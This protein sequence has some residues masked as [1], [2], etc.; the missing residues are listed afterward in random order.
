VKGRRSTYGFSVYIPSGCTLCFDD[1]S[2]HQVQ[3]MH[4][5][6]QKQKKSA[7]R[8]PCRFFCL[9]A[10]PGILCATS[11]FAQIKSDSAKTL[12]EVNVTG[13]KKQNPYSAIVP[14]QR[15]NHEALQQI[16]AESIA[17]AAR[18]FS[19]VLI[20]DYGGIG[21]LKTVSVRS[22]GGLNTGL[23]Y[24]G[25][26]IADAQ[27]GQADLGKYSATFVQSLEL[28][29]ANPQQIPLPA[30]IYS[31]ASVL[32]FTSNTY[33]ATN[34]SKNKWLAGVNAGSFGLWQPY[35][36]LYLPVGKNTILSANGEALWAKG[37]YPYRVE[38]GMFSQN[39]TRSNSDIRSFQG[40]VNMVNR[41]KDSS[42][43]QTK[44]WGYSSERGLPGS[45]IFFNDIAAQRLQDKNFFVQSQYLKKFGAATSLLVSAKYSSLF[46]K[47][48]DPNFLNN[49]G[50][51]D[52]HYTQNEIYGSLAVSHR[53]G[54]YFSISLA[55][56]LASTNLSANINEFPNPI[57]ISWWNSFTIQ[58]NKSHWQVN[59]SLLN[60]N[61]SDK[62]ETGV[63]ASNKNKFTPAFAIGYKP[64]PES[65]LLF[66]FFYKD[67]FRM[68]TF[69][70]LYYTYI[71]NTNRKLLPEYSNQY[72]A[73]FTFLKNFSPATQFSIS[74]DGYYN[75]IKDKIIAV[76]SQNLFI[77]TMQNIGKVQIKGI[78]LN[79]QVN[80]KFSQS[81]RWS[82]RLAYTWQQAIDV[83][84]P[85]SAEY[86]N[87][88][89]YTPN[90]S[91][92]ALA[93]LYYDKWSAGYSF[94]FSGV[95]YT[96]GENDPSNQ[97][98]GWNTQDVFIACQLNFR[99]FQT[100][101]RGDVN[102]IFD[103]QYDVVH[104]YPMPG[105]S[106]KLSIIIN[107]L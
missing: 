68:P 26:T 70:D 17:G 13:E 91:G 90:N 10:L 58:F 32:S 36:G 86:K 23:V 49:A 6:P 27:T 93:V 1:F 11:L 73:G 21:G 78:D 54:K 55:S 47:Y 9:L 8:T 104:Y 94:L 106:Y 64:S 25:I 4:T 56:D 20:K 35:A 38:N 2:I 62:T 45:I 5:K 81:L 3:R 76:P 37:N 102:N 79:G 100:T 80:G 33:S 69:N 99:E 22:L 61:L 107:N 15:L 52:D 85:A 77:W 31:S 66:R 12:Q 30:R 29:L 14:V 43:I 60:T 89:P 7:L 92:S 98:P 18:Y 74:L 16:N 63:A 65:P 39:A 97:L 84:D 41:F 96:L 40:E 44:I 28:D 95:R 67:I 72:D 88:I 105:R 75:N 82:A 87:E 59:A 103:E 50:G 53:M 71:P 19:G 57:R 101:I 24:D 46:T 34:F 42:T 51:L 83:T 48:T